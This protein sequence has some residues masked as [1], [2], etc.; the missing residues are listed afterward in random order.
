M[1]L[2]LGL[3]ALVKAN[4]P[5]AMT[6]LWHLDQPIY[7]PAQSKQNSKTYQFAWESDQI[8]S[9][10]NGHPQNNLDDIFGSDDR[11][12]IY[13]YRAK[14]SLNTVSQSNA[15]KFGAQLTYPGELIENVESLAEHNDLGYSPNWQQNYIQARQKK[16]PAGFPQLDLIGFP[17]HH[18]LGPLTDRNGFDVEVSI[19][20]VI[21]QKWW[22]TESKGFF[23]AEMAFSETLIPSLVKA[24]YEWVV[25]SNLH[26]SRATA[27]YPY[28]IH[29]DNNTPPNKAD[30]VN[31]AQQNWFTMSV[32]RGCT[33]TNSYPFSY[34]PHYAKYV[35]PET[36]EE[37]KIVVVP[38]DQSM[39]W[40][41]G[42]ECYSTDDMSKIAGT[43]DRPIFIVLAHDGDNAFGGGYSYYMECV[44]NLVNQAVGKGY[45]PT[46]ISQYLHDYP[47]DPNDVIHV[48][49]GAWI[50]ADGDFGDP[51]FVNWNWPLFAANGTFDVPN[52]WSDKQRTYAIAT[53][54]QN[55][56]DT[57]EAIQGKAR[58]A[59]VQ[60]PDSSATAAEL[61]YHF[62]LPSLNSGFV[63]YGT[64]ILDM[65]LKTT[66]GCNIGYNYI[67]AALGTNFNDSVAPTIWRPYRLPYN[68]GGYQMG[69]LS[70]YK[71]VKQPTDFYVYSFV[72]D[73][74]SLSRVQLFVR[75]DNDGVN[76]V[77]D[78]F[79]EIL[80][81]DNAHVGNWVTLDMTERDFPAGNF[82]NWSG[83]CFGSLEETPEV[84]ANEY[85][86]QVTGYKNALLDYYIEAEDVHGHVKRSDMFHVWVG[87]D[88]QQ[89]YE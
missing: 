40:Q 82:Y 49:D 15:P 53:A 44:Q 84:I 71:Y 38:S 72:Y 75:Q 21:S 29:G 66:V 63:Y 69:P 33:P 48:E 19:Q 58:P 45:E 36:E 6:Y 85:F 37:Y 78:N 89:A 5:L 74:S 79:N 35:D 17:Y 80:R 8:K 27:N 51:T 83:S 39:S 10:Q 62:M 59:Q 1:L 77:T 86:I 26:L 81:S 9:Q 42:Y 61:G 3:A 64:N 2:V 32:S 20:Q 60:S 7:W 46:T 13:Q 18:T 4:P 73:V 70:Q 11:K 50:N 67:K 55:W 76:P 22:G 47:V 34:M 31:P 41:D 12:A 54:T 14:D 57:A 23:P 25:V 88:S 56:I 28:S 30:Q 68:P 24:G 52:G 16:T 65:C 43:G 87:D